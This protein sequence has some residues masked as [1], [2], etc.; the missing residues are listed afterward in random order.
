[1]IK[2]TFAL[3]LCIMLCLSALPSCAK[4]ENPTC[5]NI[6]SAMIEIEINIPAGKIYN[7]RAS[8]GDDEYLEERVIN[9]LFGDGSSP[10][11]R[12]GWLDLALFLPVSAHP[13][14]LAVFLCD[15]PDTAG[16]TA[17]LLC[18]RLDVIKSTR[19]APEYSAM[20]NSA[21]VTVIGNYVLLIISEDPA[22]ALRA[23]VDMIK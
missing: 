21:T 6:L 20:L 23:A 15:T 18:R 16:D 8:R 4:H 1:M 9:S 12:E 3:F 17:R 11:V 7:L 2:R 10:P 14:E 13:C 19:K 22:L 5:R